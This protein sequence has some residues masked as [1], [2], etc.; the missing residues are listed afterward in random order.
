MTAERGVRGPKGETGN[1][2]TKAFLGLVALTF[3]ILVVV[4]VLLFRQE[5]RTKDQ[6][7]TVG[8]TNCLAGRINAK[9]QNDIVM[10]SIENRRDLV[11]VYSGQHGR[12]PNKAL[13]AVAQDA[14]RRFKG[15]FIHVA[16]DKECNT[17]VLK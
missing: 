2:A 3:A 6:I 12:P 5:Q 10:S 8:K 16:T 17:P 7:N 15:D 14:I 4:T 13:V 11:K 1:P 9:R